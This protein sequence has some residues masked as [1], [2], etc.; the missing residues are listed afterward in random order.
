MLRSGSG[1]DL[2]GKDVEINIDRS[3]LTRDVF[4][5]LNYAANN[6]HGERRTFSLVLTSGDATS[7]E[8]GGTTDPLCP[9]ILY[10]DRQIYHEALPYHYFQNAFGFNSVTM[11]CP[12]S[13]SI[14][15]ERSI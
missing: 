14:S 8:H 7:S 5:S 12:W 1:Y 11:P 3:G 6:N 13:R 10:L 15:S 2:V 9:G 4:R